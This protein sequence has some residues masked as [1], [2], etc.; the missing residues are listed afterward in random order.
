MLFLYK[1]VCISSSSLY[2]LVSPDNIGMLHL[3][4]FQL[5]NFTRF[6][7]EKENSNFDSLGVSIYCSI[8]A[9][10]PLLSSPIEKFP[11]RCS[12]MSFIYLARQKII[13]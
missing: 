12:F 3:A 13:I 5:W 10:Y 7:Y 4:F 11:S 1:V 6:L 8:S 9:V 2:M